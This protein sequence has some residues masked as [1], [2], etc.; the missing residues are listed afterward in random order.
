L[1]LDLLGFSGVRAR[2]E[3]LFDSR[4]FQKLSLMS[5]E[6]MMKL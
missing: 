3:R 1:V 4:G 2:A 5:K 6:K